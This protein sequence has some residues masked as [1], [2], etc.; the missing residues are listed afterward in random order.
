MAIPVPSATDVAAKWSTR[1]P[2]AANDYNKGVQAAGGRWQAA[3]DAGEPAYS[4]GVNSAIANHLYT[5]GTAGKAS[6]YVTKA[7]TVGTTRFGP[8]VQAAVADFQTGIGKVLAVI[9]AITL[10]PRAGVG[11]NMARAQAVADALHAAKLSGQL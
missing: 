6:K 4:V 1:T 3:V 2:N 7:S 10:P 8:G 9:G 11:N 5:A